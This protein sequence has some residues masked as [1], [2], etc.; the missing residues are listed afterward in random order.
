MNI[1]P[2]LYGATNQGGRGRPEDGPK[3]AEESLRPW[4]IRESPGIEILDLT[5]RIS[6]DQDHW[7]ALAGVVV[8]G[9]LAE[10]G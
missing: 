4:I 5:R 6:Q 2:V 1:P 3:D 7:L 9:M 8:N 10:M